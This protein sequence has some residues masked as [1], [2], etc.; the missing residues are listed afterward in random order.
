[1]G[2]LTSARVAGQRRSA[3]ELLETEIALR[4]SLEQ[5][6]DK[7]LRLEGILPICATCKQIRDERGAWHHVEIYIRDRS[8]ADFTHGLCPT[9]AAEYAVAEDTTKTG[10]Q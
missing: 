4:L 9:C 5:A 3:F 6:L 2:F 10:G 8:E 1:M 7:V